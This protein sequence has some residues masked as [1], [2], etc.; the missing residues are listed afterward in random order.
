MELN[1]LDYG[2][3]GTNKYERTYQHPGAPWVVITSPPPSPSAIL[4]EDRTWISETLREKLAKQ[5]AIKKN[6]IRDGGFLVDG[7]LWDSDFAARGAYSELALKLIRDPEYS[8]AWKASDGVWVTM[9][10]EM[11]AKVTAAGEK[12]IE[13]AFTW[14]YL[15]E[16]E[17]EETS[18]EDLP[19]FQI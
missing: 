6:T 5:I 17:L 3:V 11:F 18:D 19:N 12:H 4:G 8:T 1:Y 7:V 2:I 13:N 14:Q 10:A 15:K 9:N 16:M